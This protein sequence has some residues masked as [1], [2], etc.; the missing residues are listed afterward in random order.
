MNSYAIRYCSVGGCLMK[1]NT[2]VEIP[3]KTFFGQYCIFPGA[4]KKDRTQKRP[5]L[6]CE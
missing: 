2:A 6:V 5:V 4:P 3:D 1:K